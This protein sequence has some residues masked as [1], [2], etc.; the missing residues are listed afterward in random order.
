MPGGRCAKRSKVYVGVGLFLH[1][2]SPSQNHADSGGKV[3]SVN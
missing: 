3:I 2:C 1:L